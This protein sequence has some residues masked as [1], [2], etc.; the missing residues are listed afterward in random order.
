MLEAVKPELMKCGI[1]FGESLIGLRD[2]H[3]A[4]VKL[5]DAIEEAGGN[6]STLRVTPAGLGDPRDRSGNYQYGLRELAE[7][8]FIST[9]LA[10]KVI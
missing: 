4:Y 10:P 8:G 7:A 6:V 3:L 1:R 9:D 2:S 5:V